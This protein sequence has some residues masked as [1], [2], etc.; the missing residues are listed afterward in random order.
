MSEYSAVQL[1][2][3]APLIPKPDVSY[4]N[5]NVNVSVNRDTKLISISKSDI[6][7]NTI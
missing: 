5:D 4:L 6:N 3:L 7:I 2:A 1:V